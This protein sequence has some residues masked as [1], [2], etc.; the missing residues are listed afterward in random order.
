MEARNSPEVRID[1]VESPSNTIELAPEMEIFIVNFL[2][3]T[4]SGPDVSRARQVFEERYGHDNYFAPSSGLFGTQGYRTGETGGERA[5]RFAREVL[6]HS[7]D[8]DLFIHGSSSGAYEALETLEELLNDSKID[9]R[10][11]SL[12]IG[13]V[14]GLS[15]RGFNGLR[16]FGCD[17]VAMLTTMDAVEQHIVCPGPELLYQDDEIEDRE[18]ADVFHDT[19]EDRQQRRDFFR[20]NLV[21]FIPDENV[22]NQ[23]LGKLNTLDIQLQLALYSGDN[24]SVK[25]L[26]AEREKLL[27]PYKELYFHGGLVPDEKTQEYLRQYQELETGFK[28][29]LWMTG[30]SLAFI[31]RILATTQSGYQEKLA[32][33]VKLA[34]SKGVTLSVGVALM[35]RDPIMPPEYI[36]LVKERFNEAGVTLSWMGIFE[37]MGHASVGQYPETIVQMI[38][39]MLTGQNR[40]PA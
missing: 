12:V 6:N 10:N 13:A 5:K 16:S 25:K 40:T 17:Y 21:R 32:S 33:L 8:K 36:D 4:A 35:Q 14:P 24:V 22:R 11:I 39:T 31:G 7:G 3:A 37:Q 20:L 38:D 19:S 1:R 18:D 26:T 2:G 28:S 9:G 30:Q 15:E 27:H 23:F 29:R 34:E